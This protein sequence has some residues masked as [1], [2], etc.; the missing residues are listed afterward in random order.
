LGQP[1]DRVQDR[2]DRRP[3]DLQRRPKASTAAEVPTFSRYQIQG[4][5]SAAS[6]RPWVTRASRQ[7][8]REDDGEDP[9]RCAP[10]P[11]DGCR[12]HQGERN[13]DRQQQQV[14]GGRL[15]ARAQ[16]VEEGLR[17]QHGAPEGDDVRMI[18]STRACVNRS[19][20][21]A[22]S[23]RGRR[24]AGSTAI[25]RAQSSPRVAPAWPGMRPSSIAAEQIDL[26]GGG[27]PTSTY[28]TRTA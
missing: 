25:G 3:R 1:G 19:A 7:D 12:D 9:P 13:E 28:F 10:D 5:P 26:R 2:D 4:E 6:T 20:P 27:R 22:M 11:R 24:T 16:R 8:D 18:R 15:L 21:A 17:A 23:P 14:R